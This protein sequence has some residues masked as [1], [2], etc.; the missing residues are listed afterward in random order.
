MSTKSPYATSFNSAIKNGTPAGTAVSAIAKRTGK[1]AP[2]V[3]ASLHNAGL[4]HRQKLNNQWIYWPAATV[5][6]SAT[7]ARTSQLEMWQYFVDWC[8]ASGYCTTKQLSAHAGSQPGFITWCRTFF[9]RQVTAGQATKTRK[10]G[11]SKTAR[12]RTKTRARRTTR[13]V[14]YKFPKT[15]TRRYQRAA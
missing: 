3:F 7:N 15:A 12:R 2:A 4:C 5:K 13:T 6:A 11:K 14:S 1:A 9:N 8:L 10:H